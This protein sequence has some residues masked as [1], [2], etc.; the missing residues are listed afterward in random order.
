MF[1]AVLAAEKFFEAGTHLGITLLPVYM[2]LGALV[3]IACARLFRLFSKENK[4]IV[5]SLFPENHPTLRKLIS[6]FVLH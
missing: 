6:V 1:L 3:Y 5:L 4:D 2:I